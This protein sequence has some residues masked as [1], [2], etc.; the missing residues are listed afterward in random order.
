[1]S[2]STSPRVRSNA[3]R[4]PKLLPPRAALLVIEEPCVRDL[5]AAHL[6]AIGWLPVLA[7][8]SR[9]AVRIAGQVLPD[10]IVVDLDTPATAYSGWLGDLSASLTRGRV[11]RTV[12]LSSRVDQD[13]AAGR[14][15]GKVDLWVSKPLD[16]GNLTSRLVRLLQSGRAQTRSTGKPPPIR[17]GPVELDRHQ[18]TL[19]VRRLGTWQTCNLPRTEHRLLVLLAGEPA[20]VHSRDAI[21]ELLWPNAAIDRRTV[22]QYVRRLRKS[23]IGLGIGDLVSTVIGAGY[24]LR[25]EALPSD[26]AT[27]S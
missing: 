24:R 3:S 20:Q 4:G 23:L 16:A 7:P 10:V 6:R 27:A 11:V 21:C 2:E 12:M 5:V 22:D 25:T 26:E 1:M 14:V 18:P 8:T 9:E 15:S 17:L 19:R 13:R